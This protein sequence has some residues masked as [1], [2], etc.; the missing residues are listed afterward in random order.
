MS[1]VTIHVVDD[2]ESFL[3]AVARLLR[4]SGYAVETHTSAA[5]FLGE[6]HANDR[7]CVISDLRMPGMNGLEMQEALARA[8]HIMPV[9]FLT[10]NGD[11]P[12][13]VSAIQKGAVDYIE[14]CAPKEILLAAVQRALSRESDDHGRRL[15]RAQLK[16]RLAALSEREREVLS[17]VVQGKMNKEIAADLGI[18]ERTVKLHRTAITTKL[19]VQSVAELTR[20]WLQAGH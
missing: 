16:S 20:L 15:K 3:R 5:G 1:E 18:H 12:S 6:R 14:K 13:T 9:I 7:G 11:I 17:E 8:G 10:G 4:A 2:D 19:Q